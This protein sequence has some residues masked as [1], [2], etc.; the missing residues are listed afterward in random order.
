MKIYKDG[1]EVATVNQTLAAGSNWTSMNSWLKPVFGAI[2]INGTLGRF[3]NIRLG[4]VLH[5]KKSL[6]ATEVSNNYN[7]TKTNYGL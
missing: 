3:N 7:S 2:N 5:Y 6:T 1:T 4:E